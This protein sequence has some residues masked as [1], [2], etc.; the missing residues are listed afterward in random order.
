[1]DIEKYKRIIEEE[2]VESML[3]YIEFDEEC[4]YNEK[5]V[6]KCKK[7]LINYFS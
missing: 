6:E 5:D 7:L 2:I 3:S 1:M 4:I